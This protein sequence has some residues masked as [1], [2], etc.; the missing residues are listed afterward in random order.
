MSHER[1]DIRDAVVTLLTGH[2]SAGAR[3]F[4]SRTGP[5]RE[6]E[7]PCICVFVDGEVVD[8]VFAQS[9]PRVLSR[10]L[11][12]AVEGWAKVASGGDLDAAMD[13]LATE[14]EAAMDADPYFG[15]AAFYSYLSGTDFAVKM[16]GA[17]PI[18]VVH[19]S[20]TVTYR[21]TPRVPPVT[22]A[23]DTVHTETSID[24]GAADPV[25]DVVDL[26]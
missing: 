3:V 26:T 9:A 4:R 17:Q 6:A 7:I 22:D 18:G 19:L 2:T 23:L 5:L 1:A 13:T 14:I 16:D 15:G 12:L 21:T 10:E 20:Y 25:V 11:T 24:A 8:Q